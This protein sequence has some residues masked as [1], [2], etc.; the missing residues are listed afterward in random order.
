MQHAHPHFKTYIGNEDLAAWRAWC[1]QELS[2]GYSP[3]EYRVIRVIELTSSCTGLEVFTTV[4]T[5]TE[6][7][8]AQ[9]DR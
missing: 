4:Q 3:V 9:R 8:V 2:T 1:V 5:K 7:L 6:T